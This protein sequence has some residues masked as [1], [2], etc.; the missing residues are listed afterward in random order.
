MYFFL[1]FIKS[2]ELTCQSPLKHA[3]PIPNSKLLFFGLVTRHGMRTPM[4]SYSPPETT[5]F[6]R[7]DGSSAQAPRMHVS[8]HNGIYRRY[9]RVQDPKYTMFK[10]NCDEGELI[11]EGMEQHFELGS[12]YRKFLIEEMKFLPPYL[13]K[14]LLSVRA[15]KVERCI[16]SAVSFLNGLYPPAVPGERIPIITGTN[17]NEFLYPSS[18]GCSDLQKT[19][20]KF[21]A[22]DEFINR[23]NSS[24]TLYSEIYEKLKLKPDITNWMFLGDWMISYLC[25]NQSIPIIPNLSDN[26]IQQSIKDIAYFS[27]GFF[28]T[29]RAVAGSPIWRRIFKDID[30]YLSGKSNIGKFKFYSAHDTTI[31]ALLVSLGYYDIKLPSFRSHFGIEIWEDLNSKILIRLVFNGEPVPIDFMN[32]ETIINYG[33]L[34]TIMA[35]R[36]DLNYCKKEFP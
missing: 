27:Y 30:D 12:F 5:G 21:I 25:T 24:I 28:K 23:M 18:N 10:P 32:N 36:G 7:C 19:W 26:I 8:N 3:T 13:D 4:D 2:Y 31:I 29:D 35:Q 15:S 11:L 9:A 22:T 20:D 17:S 6:W 33:T 1:T 34:K 14:D 16:R